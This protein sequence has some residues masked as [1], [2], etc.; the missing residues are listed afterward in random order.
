ML[1]NEL[2]KNLGFPGKATFRAEFVVGLG[3][4]LPASPTVLSHG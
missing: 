4:A 3:V 1:V 2:L